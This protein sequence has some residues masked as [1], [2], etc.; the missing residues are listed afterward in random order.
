MAMVD[1]EPGLTPTEKL[2]KLHEEMLNRSHGDEIP[3][4]T[5]MVVDCLNE[6][7]DMVYMSKDHTHT[8]S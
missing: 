6:L 4:P 5:Q 1:F 8:I 2:A 3:A 7:W